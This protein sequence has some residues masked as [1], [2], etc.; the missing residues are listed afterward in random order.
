MPSPPASGTDGAPRYL[1][2]SGTQSYIDPDDRLERVPDELRRITELFREYGFAETLTD[3]RLD[4]AAQDFKAGLED[5]LT[6]DA[7]DPEGAAVVYYTGHGFTT[8]GGHYLAFRD[9]VIGKAARAVET[10]ELV[11]LVGPTPR[12]RRLL[13]IIDACESGGGL[14]DAVQRAARAA[15][16]QLPWQWREGIWVIA[17]TRPKEKA[18]QSAF[19]SAFVHAVRQAAETTGA[20]QEFLAIEVILDNVNKQLKGSGQLATAAPASYGTGLLPIFRNP[21]YFAAHALRAASYRRDLY[22]Q[23]AGACGTE[24]LAKRHRHAA[25]AGD[26]GSG[27][28]QVSPARPGDSRNGARAVGIGAETH[29]PGPDRG[30]DRS[31]GSV[32]GA[33]KRADRVAAGRHADRGGRARRVGAAVRNHGRGP[34]A[35]GGGVAAAVDSVTAALRSSAAVRSQDHRPRQADVLRAGRRP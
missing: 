20:E 22:W 14:L 19:V 21:A 32:W 3:L 25:A 18:A 11:T 13:I 6:D 33:H 34:G 12:V 7:Q 31:G 1:I 5:W 2:A 16:W 26:R 28:R 27:I 24:S 29:V 4:P 17:A 15:T 10:G 23:G 9:T 35:A 30:L 8:P